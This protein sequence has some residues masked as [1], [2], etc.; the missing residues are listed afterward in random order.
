MA[1]YVPL[2]IAGAAAY[3]LLVV[4][5]SLLSSL[6][7]NLTG[8]LTPAAGATPVSTTPTAPCQG[9]DKKTG[10]ACDCPAT[11]AAAMAYAFPATFLSY[12]SSSSKKSSSKS[13]SSS[14]SKSSSGSSSSTTASG[15]TS[16]A[17]SSCDC[18]ACTTAGSTAAPATPAPTKGTGN[19][20][21]CL[22]QNGKWAQD[23]SFT[24]KCAQI[25]KTCTASA[26]V[27]YADLNSYAGQSMAHEGY[28]F[29]ALQAYTRRNW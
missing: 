3:Y 11:T 27:A 24:Q 5:P 12:K 22:C 10:A 9:K 7:S 14:K 20:I 8:A 6:T 28:G 25:G 13:S 15:S 21:W 19:A 18:S 16:T 29:N 4:N 2:I 26:G 17:S 1:D 23:P